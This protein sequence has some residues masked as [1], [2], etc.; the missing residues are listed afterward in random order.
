[1]ARQPKSD[2][3]RKVLDESLQEL[4]TVRTLELFYERFEHAT[5][6]A[7]I[8]GT[9]VLA[10]LLEAIAAAEQRLADQ[11]EYAVTGQHPRK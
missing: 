3:L 6:H 11:R 9:P 1:M 7:V 10:A 8:P 5:A 2:R 4:G